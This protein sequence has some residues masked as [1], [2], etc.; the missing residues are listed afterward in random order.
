MPTPKQL[1]PLGDP[2]RP[3]RSVLTWCCWVAARRYGL[4]VPD[5]SQETC[6]IEQSHVTIVLK[7]SHW[8]ADDMTNATQLGAMI[9]ARR[10]GLGLSQAALA[11][12]A[13]VSR[14]SVNRL[15]GGRDNARLSLVLNVLE[16]LD[17]DVD[18]ADRSKLDDG[19]RRT[20]DAIFGRDVL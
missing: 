8:R 19:A 1:D 12:R 4:G 14:E 10:E 18:L 17:L 11:Q 2:Y 5:R 3:Y 13:L 9:R 16:A 20:L 7:R 6:V 15:E